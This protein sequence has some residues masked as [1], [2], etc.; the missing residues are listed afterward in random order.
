MPSRT[1]G[2][3]GEKLL[4][5]A[6]QRKLHRFRRVFRHGICENSQAYPGWW[7]LL[8]V[9]NAACASPCLRGLSGEIVLRSPIWL[10]SCY[11]GDAFVRRRTAASTASRSTTFAFGVVPLQSACVAA[12]ANNRRKALPPGRPTLSETNTQAWV[13]PS[14]FDRK[15]KPSRVTAPLSRQKPPAYFDPDQ[16]QQHSAVSSPVSDCNPSQPIRFEDFT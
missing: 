15:W 3:G 13:G 7:Q 1:A 14:A 16:C 4:F 6:Q 5:P 9:P 10:A 8:A 11:A 2:R 12:V